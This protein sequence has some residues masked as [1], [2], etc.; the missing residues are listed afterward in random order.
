VNIDTVNIR[1]LNNQSLFRRQEEEASGNIKML[2]EVIVIGKKIIR[3]SKNLN[4][5]GEADVTLTAADLDKAGKV[6]LGM[7]LEKNLQGFRIG[8]KL[9]RTYMVNSMRMR[10]V[11]DGVYV[12]SL[13]PDGL[14]TYV[15]YKNFFDYY[16]AEDIKGVEIM[17]TGKYQMSYTT[18]FLDPLAV[19]WDNVFV[20]VTTYGG[21]GP[22]LKKVPGIYLYKPMAFAAPLGFYAP[23]YNAD[24][25]SN[26]VDARSTIH[27]EP[28]IITDKNGS[29]IVS[30][31]TADHP[32][33]YTIIIQGSDMSG[34]VGAAREKLLIKVP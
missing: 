2:K 10:L 18:R 8:G 33:N 1:S 31:F 26:F 30:F 6:T 28:N 23:K 24:A 5:P 4:G 14:S 22:F 17:K 15:Y 13:Q 21:Q 34:S 19:P 20:E 3:D 32:G 25:V 29:A 7:L 27:W 9:G 12:E 11:I 16:T